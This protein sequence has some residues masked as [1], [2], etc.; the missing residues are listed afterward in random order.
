MNANSDD[1]FAWP[2]AVINFEVLKVHNESLANIKQQPVLL[3]AIRKREE[4][5][6]AFFGIQT[7]Y[8]S[9]TILMRLSIRQE[10][11]LFQN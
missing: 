5:Q 1:K 10:I 8:L 9:T 4:K 7:S 3:I 6:A 2:G 11:Q